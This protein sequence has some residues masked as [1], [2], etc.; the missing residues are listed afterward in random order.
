MRGGRF[1]AGLPG[2]FRKVKCYSAA[3]VS[4]LSCLD[5]LAVPALFGNQYNTI[6]FI[7]LKLVI[8]T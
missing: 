2:R 7:L 3:V 8:L 6:R 4:V 5:R 1:P